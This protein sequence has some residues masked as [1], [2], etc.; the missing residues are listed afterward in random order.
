MEK[1]ITP[2]KYIREEGILKNAGDLIA[3][4]GKKVF[5]LGG[6]TALDKVKNDLNDG[7][8]KSGISILKTVWYGGECSEKNIKNL[9]EE[10]LA[11]GAD[12]I[13]GVGGG[14]ALDT[15]KVVA[16]RTNLPVVTIPTLAS[17]CAAWTPISIMYT[18]E[19]EFI[20]IC[21]EAAN[22]ALVM[23]EPKIIAEAPVRYL[24][25]GIG[26]TLAKWYEFEIAARNKEQDVA[27]VT[28]L[29]IAK[30][31]TEILIQYGAAAKKAAEEKRVDFSLN[32]IIDANIMLGGMVSG[33]GGADLR[34]AAA[35]AIYSGLTIIPEL[36]E[37]YHGEIVAYGIL[38]QCALDKQSFEDVKN[39]IAFYQT[40]D[41]P[42]NLTQ[43]GLKDVQPE[44]LKTAAKLATEIEDMR[45][46]PFA[47]SPEMVYNAILT[48][49]DWGNKFLAII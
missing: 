33:L 43:M 28:G 19:G 5:I 27:T 31:C 1:I 32:Q 23:V 39:L 40:V 44:K 42:I 25:A 2:N 34:T 36:H 18:D 16:Y 4:L 26:D 7:L 12:V 15:A 35:H 48:A 11:S 41:L 46:V 49:D 45:N 8:K 29:A 9:T 6:K 14:K 38:C 24:T 13:L 21:Y 20:N 47:V 3:V 10:V 22:P 17:T 37:M 30:L